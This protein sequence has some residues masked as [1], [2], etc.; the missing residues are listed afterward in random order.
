M[1]DAKLYQG[2]FTLGLVEDLQQY[3]YDAIIATYS[4]HHL[5]DAQKVD[6][7]LALLPL[8]SAGGG[9]YIGDVAFESRK[10]LERCMAEA[11]DAWDDGEYYCVFDELKAHFPAM[12]FEQ[13]STC[14]GVLSLPP[15]C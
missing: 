1:P 3:Q 4:L 11:G 14:A 13:I 6:F 2:D 10:A 8:L 5:T 7:L 12:K 9:I 15:S